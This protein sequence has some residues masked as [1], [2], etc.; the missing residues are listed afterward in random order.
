MTS[1]G[2]SNNSLMCVINLNSKK[3]S[4]DLEDKGV[5]PN[6]SLILKPPKIKSEFLNPIY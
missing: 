3:M 4:E 1:V 2:F 5:V 6:K